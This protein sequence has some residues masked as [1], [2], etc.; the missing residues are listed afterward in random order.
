MAT[1]TEREEREFFVYETKRTN[2]RCGND[3]L[4]LT[5]HNRCDRVSAAN[6]MARAV[7]PLLARVNS[8]HAV[9]TVHRQ[10]PLLSRAAA[11]AV[12]LVACVRSLSLSRTLP[13][14][15]FNICLQFQRIRFVLFHLPIVSR[16]SQLRRAML[17]NISLTFVFHKRVWI[18]CK[19]ITVKSLFYFTYRIVVFVDFSQNYLFLWFW[20]RCESNK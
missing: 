10:T 1:M 11:A 17:S 2:E 7:W 16:V 13:T 20:P 4:A 15:W 9:H 19:T 18:A 3:A 12:K 8:A 14:I 5:T 6:W